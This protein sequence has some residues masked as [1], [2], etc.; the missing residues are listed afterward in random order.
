MLLIFGAQWR[1]LEP[2]F[3]CT[4]AICSS[5]H[6]TTL[7]ASGNTQPSDV[8]GAQTRTA[9]QIGLARHQLFWFWAWLFLCKTVY[10]D[11]VQQFWYCTSAKNGTISAVRQLVGQ[12]LQS[13]ILALH[14]WKQGSKSEWEEDRN[15]RFWQLNHNKI[16]VSA[17]TWMI[18]RKGKK[19]WAILPRCEG[20]GPVKLLEQQ[21]TAQWTRTVRNDQ[22]LTHP[23]GLDLGWA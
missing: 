20:G 8:T 10:F 17:C 3:H 2:I 15:C 12:S 16:T 5:R 23:T 21:L 19:P 1:N 4:F 7:A 9:L 6:F 13:T 22:M 11:K 18:K 14:L